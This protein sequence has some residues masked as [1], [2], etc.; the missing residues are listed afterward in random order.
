[1]RRPLL[2]PGW[3]VVAASIYIVAI[4]N[5]RF[6]SQAY[7]AVA[8]AEVYEWLF[9]AAALVALVAAHVAAL[10]LFATRYVLKPLIAVLIVVTA[11]IAYWM[12]E[13]GVVIDTNMLRNAVETDTREAFDLVTPHLLAAVTLFG[14]LPA[15]LLSRTKID[16]PPLKRVVWLNARRIAGSVALALAAA[17]L[18]AM[19]FTSVA[20][21]QHHLLLSLAPANAIRAA[22]RYARKSQIATAT[23]LETVGTDARKG[24]GWQGAPRPFIT[25]LVVGET[26]RAENFSLNGYA[27]ATNPKLQ[28]VPDLLYYR[29]VSSCGTDTA[30]SVPCIFSGLGRGAFSVDAASHRENLLDIVRRAGLDVLWRENQSGC[31]GTCARVPTETLTAVKQP[32]F[33]SDGE[34]HDEI[35]LHGLKEKLT[36]MTSGGLVVLHMM[37]SHG[38]AYFKRVP[39]EFRKF[40]PT[41]DSSQFSRCTSEEIVNSYDNTVLY[42]DHVLARLIG[43]LGEVGTEAAHTAMIYVSD[44]GESLGEH[45]LYLHGMP[46]R[47]APEQQTHVPMLMWLSPGYGRA[48]GL[49][50][51]CL[52]QKAVAGSYSHDNVFHT[53]LGLLDIATSAYSQ[54][55]DIV[56]SC[57]SADGATVSH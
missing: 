15:V 54:K 23:P 20:R 3:L 46:Y 5:V 43:V 32:E 29:Q 45:G 19:D 35:L 27:R 34:C 42:T 48:L 53:T 6:W 12:H 10:S 51:T 1:M 47:L 56:S 49:D 8:P 31:K 17:G 36:A 25:V 33:C 37:G 57:K 55:L 50:Q 52:S 13:Y 2:S 26:A 30:Y 16:W 14:V 24:A 22:I 7:Q 11:S 18:F 41:C 21:E 44:H 28:A 40:T 4:L 38:P 9:L 39:A